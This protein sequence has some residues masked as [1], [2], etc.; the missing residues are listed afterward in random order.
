MVR[1]AVDGRGRR[2]HL[3]SARAANMARREESEARSAG[4]GALGLAP[5]LSHVARPV[6]AGRV[7]RDA[8]CTLAQLSLFKFSPSTQTQTGHYIAKDS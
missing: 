3:E 2:R 5:A 1:R 7:V 4:M 8:G 6:M